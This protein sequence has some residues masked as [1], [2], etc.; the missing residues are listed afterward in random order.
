MRGGLRPMW[1]S[2]WNVRRA[3]SISSSS[4]HK[5]ISVACRT[6]STRWSARYGSSIDHASGSP[7]GPFA[8]TQPQAKRAQA[9]QSQ[10]ARL[11]YRLQIDVRT[12][13][14]RRLESETAVCT[15]FRKYV[16]KAGDPE[17]TAAVVRHR[18]HARGRLPWIKLN[19]HRTRRQMEKGHL[20]A[21]SSKLGRGSTAKN[22]QSNGAKELDRA[23]V[24]RIATVK[25][26]AVEL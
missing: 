25:Q 5:R 20:S 17:S 14:S 10:R 6:P 11:R 24:R 21:K 1:C 4:R 23:H 16:E 22:G 7:P 19:H 9:R 26:C 13:R 18:R 12:P 15:Q 3:C 2:P 8:E